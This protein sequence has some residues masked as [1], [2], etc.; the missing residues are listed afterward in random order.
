MTDI[1]DAQLTLSWRK[2]RC[3]NKYKYL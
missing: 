3:W 2:K 1:P